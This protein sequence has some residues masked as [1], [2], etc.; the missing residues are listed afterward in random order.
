MPREKQR[1]AKGKPSAWPQTEKFL[2][3]EALKYEEA[4][5]EDMTLQPGSIA[6][7]VFLKYEDEVFSK[8]K[9]KEYW[10]A[11]GAGYNLSIRQFSFRVKSFKDAE[12]VIRYKEKII[13]IDPELINE[14]KALRAAV[15][16]EMIHA[17]DLALDRC[18]PLPFRDM[19]ITRLYDILKIKIENL[20]KHLMAFSHLGNQYRFLGSGQGEH[21]LLFFLKSLD[22][23]IRTGLPFGTVCGQCVYIPKKKMR[24]KKIT[25]I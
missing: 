19:L 23:D 3:S 20:D 7:D 10:S 5:F 22:L 8:K 16:H 11:K 24:V 18:F 15:L 14:P 9:N 13:F 1:A 6:G 12:A 2:N 17:Y 25:C 4:F 21:G